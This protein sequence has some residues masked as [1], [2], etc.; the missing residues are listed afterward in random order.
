M[1]NDI[2]ADIAII[3]SLIGAVAMMAVVVVGVAYLV[4][5]VIAPLF[6]REEDK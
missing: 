2:L 3:L 4:L 1:T 6:E 5:G